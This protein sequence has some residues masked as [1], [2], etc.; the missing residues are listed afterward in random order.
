MLENYAEEVLDIDPLAPSAT[1]SESRAWRLHVRDMAYK[2]IGEIRSHDDQH[3][4]EIAEM[5]ADLPEHERIWGR[6]AS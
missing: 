3:R 2:L 5:L 4:T 6:L 1:S